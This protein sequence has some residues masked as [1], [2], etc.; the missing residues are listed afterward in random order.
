MTAG[1]RDGGVSTQEAAAAP[2]P[3]LPLNLHAYETAARACLPRMIFD[4]VAAGSDDEVTLRENR[5]AFDRWRLLPRMWRGIARPDLTTTVLGQ[6]VSL[7]VL[8]GPLALQRLVHDAGE[9][10]SAAAAR[11]AGTIFTLGTCAS[12]TIEAVAA[13]AGRWWFQLYLFPDRAIARDLVQRAGAAGASALV[14]TIDSPVLGSHEVNQRNNFADPEGIVFAN[15]APEALPGA[16]HDPEQSWRDLE[17]LAALTHLPLVLKG[18]LD[19]ADAERAFASGAR[20][21]VVSNHGGRQLDSAVASLDALPAVAEVAA[22]RGEVLIDG[23]FRRG[24]DVLKA[25]A[26]GARAVLLGRPFVWGLAVNGE[27]GVLHVLELL[28]AEIARDMYLSGRAS[29][30]EIDRS[31]VVPPGP[32]PS[33]AGPAGGPVVHR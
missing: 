9:L 21:V 8:L 14:I 24:T 20:A 13:Q 7:P 16:R 15:V 10:A 6:E 23:G 33:R 2:P 4:M 22:G 17:W 1:G 19:P 32:L 5:A 25:L 12:C 30:A 31:L 27:E 29:M 18:I 26:L 28:R 3:A 11:R